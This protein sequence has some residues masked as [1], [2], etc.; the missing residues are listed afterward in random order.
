[1]QRREREREENN[2]RYKW[3]SKLL[4]SEET[5]SNC[6]LLMETVFKLRC[7]DKDTDSTQKKTRAL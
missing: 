1:M 4:Y 7:D 2:A 3:Y 6:K 5:T